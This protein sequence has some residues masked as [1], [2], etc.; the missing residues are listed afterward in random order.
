[1]ENRLGMLF[2]PKEN[3]GRKVGRWFLDLDAELTA[4]GHVRHVRAVATDVERIQAIKA[5]ATAG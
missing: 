5:W 3:E 2:V 1:M 4:L